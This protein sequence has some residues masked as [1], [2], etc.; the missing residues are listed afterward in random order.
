MRKFIKHKYHTRP[1][2][3]DDIY[4]DSKKESQYYGQLKILQ[5]AGEVLFFIRQ[6][7]FDLPGGIKYRVD[8]VEFHKDQSV[9][10]VDVKGYM[11]Q[12][13]KNKIKQVEALY[14]IKIE[15]K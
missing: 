8:F 5:K 7:G 1:Q 11:T 9:H 12:L 14:P 10:F 13:A 15:I 2:K 4:F 6:V 3:V